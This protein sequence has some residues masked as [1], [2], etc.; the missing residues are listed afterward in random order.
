MC[1]DI[2]KKY[3]N[4]VLIS[5]NEIEQNSKILIYGNGKWGKII[6][7]KISLQ[8]K[9]VEIVGF[10]DSYKDGLSGKLPVYKFD[11]NLNYK[12][13]CSLILVCSVFSKEIVKLLNTNK[14]V[15]YKVVIAEM[16]PHE[17]DPELDNMILI[18]QIGK[19][20]S[21]TIFK[22]LKE[23]AILD[24]IYHL[25]SINRHSLENAIENII[26][27]D[28]EDYGMFAKCLRD[29][30]L[31]KIISKN[32]HTKLKVISAVRDPIARHISQ[33]FES[34]KGHIRNNPQLVK[35]N[36][37]VDRLVF[38]MPRVHSYRLCL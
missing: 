15:L 35:S 13:S 38:D 18:H 1:Q 5:L 25:H 32:K 29:L 28:D 4:H 12:Q 24:N 17:F 16:L 31:N 34:L 19:V 27:E 37:D 9:D 2:L 6:K 20:V 22:S 21:I 30:S 11:P 3:I 8:R 33:V 10:L 26:C 23:A 7:E 14:Q 36:G